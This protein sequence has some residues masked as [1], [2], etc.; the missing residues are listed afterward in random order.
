M[1]LVEK[2]KSAVATTGR[3][4]AAEAT[5]ANAVSLS[6]PLIVGYGLV[7]YMD[8]PVKLSATIGAA[9]LTDALDGWIARR[10]N[11]ESKLGAYVDIAADRT[12]ELMVL[13]S[14]ANNGMISDVFFDICLARTIFYDP[15][16]IMAGI[17]SVEKDN[18][19]SLEKNDGRVERTGYAVA[20][21]GFMML[22]PHLSYVANNLL[23]IIPASIEVYRLIK[24][25]FY[26]SPTYNL[27]AKEWLL[28]RMYGY[29]HPTQLEAN[30]GNY[31]TRLDEL[32]E[33]FGKYIGGMDNANILAP[34]ESA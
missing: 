18:P 26:G 17:F 25:D 15:Q 28:N 14:F 10:S 4:V 19:L 21:A 22:A 6:R 16:R 1:S 27:R 30:G 23:G 8:D 5:L 29:R 24:F 33:G 9:F 11:N 2:I 3:F 7:N 31:L 20:K 32:V 12:L 34:T 13:S